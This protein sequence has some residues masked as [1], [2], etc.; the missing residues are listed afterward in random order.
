MLL[1]DFG[2]NDQREDILEQNGLE[3][4]Q[5]KLKHEDLKA[6]FDSHENLSQFFIKREYKNEDDDDDG[7]EEEDDYE[8][9]DSEEEA[10]RVVSNPWGSDRHIIDLMH[11]FMRETVKV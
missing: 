6:I 5:L 8:N 9:K 11:P 2:F 7:E 10:E 4:E 1:P 3:I